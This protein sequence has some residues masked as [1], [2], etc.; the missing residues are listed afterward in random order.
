MCVEKVKY[1]QL[2]NTLLNMII[3]GIQKE[4]QKS[5]HIYFFFFSLLAAIVDSFYSILL[6]IFSLLHVHFEVE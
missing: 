6:T 4:T 1:W 2:H 3:E 5:A